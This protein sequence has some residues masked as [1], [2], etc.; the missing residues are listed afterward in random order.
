[1]TAIIASTTHRLLSTVDT[2]LWTTMT[3]KRQR[4]ENSNRNTCKAQM[5]LQM[6]AQLQ[7]Q[8]K[9]HT[10]GIRDEKQKLNRNRP[11]EDAKKCEQYN[12][13]SRHA[14]VNCEW[15][16]AHGY[17]KRHRSEYKC[18]EKQNSLETFTQHP[19]PHTGHRSPAGERNTMLRNAQQA[20]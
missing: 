2:T 16:C 8:I 6:Q 5:Q 12:N 3:E 17:A 10:N 1:M 9:I 14:D 18:I 19:N 7:L 13:L 11:Q 4:N 20:K 15:N